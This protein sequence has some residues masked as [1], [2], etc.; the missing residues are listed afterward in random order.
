[1]AAAIAAARR[2]VFWEIYIFLDDV[3]GR[4]FVDLLCERAN[5]GVEVRLLLDAVGS[6][7]L[8]AAAVKRLEA[9]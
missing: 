8:S 2:S 7:S 6:F 1:M 3:E 4:R 9:R 5:A